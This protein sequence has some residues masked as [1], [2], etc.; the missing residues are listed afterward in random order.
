MCLNGVLVNI[1]S[2]VMVSVS[3]QIRDIGNEGTVHS[4]RANYPIS[5]RAQGSLA[6]TPVRRTSSKLVFGDLGMDHLMLD[7]REL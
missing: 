4:S 1:Q 5:Q 6:I 7:H 3:I 2:L